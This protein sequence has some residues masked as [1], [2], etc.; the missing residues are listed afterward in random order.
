MC[1][2]FI[3]AYELSWITLFKLHNHWNNKNISNTCAELFQNSTIQTHK[4]YLTSFS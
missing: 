4:H 3:K 1:Q 2:T